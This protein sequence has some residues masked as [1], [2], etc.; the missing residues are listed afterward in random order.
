[1]IIILTH[2]M[3]HI[4]VILLILCI[5]P[6]LFIIPMMGCAGSGDRDCSMLSLKIILF[7]I[8][9]SKIMGGVFI[10]AGVLICLI[11]PQGYT[12]LADIP[13]KFKG[14]LFPS[15]KDRPPQLSY[16]I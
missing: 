14:L 4:S 8:I 16:C 11:I 5:L 12:V 15:I 9:M 10:L 2:R 6:Y 3:K 13:K 1:M 7:R